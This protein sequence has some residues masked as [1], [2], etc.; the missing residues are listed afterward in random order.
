MS[1]GQTNEA[2]QAFRKALAFKPDLAQAAHIIA[3]LEGKTTQAAPHEYIKTLFDNYA[4]NFE[5]HLVG[6]LGYAVP[7]MLF[8][9]FASL[10]VNG[11]GRIRH[12]L[13]LGC[14]T[15]LSGEQFRT[16]A[17]RLTGVDLSEKMLDVA[18][19]KQIYDA[20]HVGDIVT[21]LRQSPD[22]YDLF[23]ASDVFVYLGG[24]EEVFQAIQERSLPG[25]YVAFSTERK[26]GD[27][28]VLQPTA[29]YAHSRGYITSLCD[30]FGF[31]LLQR[32]AVNVRKDQDAWVPGDIYL[33]QYP[34]N[35]Q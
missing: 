12:A 18:A 11:G 26:D 22:F 17:D 1:L 4:K 24:L 35:W 28:F 5:K 20:L 14:G 15:G 31:R 25:A 16:V 29:R 23:M 32:E 33:L 9:R 34:A 13:D 30:H 2:L 19:G 7:R 3:V 27:G 8:R 6:A 10:M 21:F